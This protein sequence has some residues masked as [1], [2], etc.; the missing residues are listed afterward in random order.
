MS[1]ETTT[2]TKL[3]NKTI[4]IYLTQ[5]KQKCLKPWVE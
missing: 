3:I 1:W 2:D 4:S 5:P